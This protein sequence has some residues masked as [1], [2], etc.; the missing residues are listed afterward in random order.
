MAIRSVLK[1]LL[2][3]LVKN[4]LILSLLSAAVL[5]STIESAPFIY[6]F[7]FPFSL[8]ITDILL[9]SELNSNSSSLSNEVY[10]LKT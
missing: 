10:F 1:P 4:C 5:F 8:M 7:N 9:R 2:E 3:K 6:I